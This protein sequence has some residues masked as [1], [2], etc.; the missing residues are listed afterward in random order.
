MV[1]SERPKFVLFGSSIVQYAFNNN[2]W[3]SILADLYSRKADIVLRGYAGWN[4]RRALQVLDKVFPKTASV[5]PDLAIV[6]FGGNDS[7]KPHPSGLGPH[8]PLP[9]YVENMKKIALHVK[10]LSDKTRVIFL[11]S[12]P[13]NETQYCNFFGVRFGWQN[14]T[15]ELS[16]VYAK[17]CVDMCK[18]LD[19]QVIDLWSVLQKQSDFLSTC[20]TDGIHLSPVGSKIVA[21][22]ILRVLEETDWEPNLHWQFLPT[23]FD[24][25]SP[26]DHLAPD[27]KSTL[28][29][30]DLDFYR[31]NNWDEAK[32]KSDDLME[33]GV[34]KI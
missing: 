6:Y 15:N 29:V 14:R 25:D 32:Q 27:G 10:S 8:V 23:E 5:Q 34:C 12:P 24:E 16:G 7:S 22:E 33:H 3:A 17:A 1:G 19:I 30:S 26:Y 9:E 18:E 28:N 2:G 13:V 21:D 4:S 11:T 20:F 31:E